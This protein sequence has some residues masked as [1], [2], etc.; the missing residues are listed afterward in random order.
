MATPENVEFLI[1]V[2]TEVE[3]ARAR[4]GATAQVDGRFEGAIEAGHLVI[5]KAGSVTGTARTETA[6]IHG[7]FRG[8]I[9]VAGLL[10]VRSSGLVE[11]EISYGSLAI[12]SGGQ[13]VGAL[14]QAEPG[15]TEARE[16][17]PSPAPAVVREVEAIAEVEAEPDEDWT[18]EPDAAV[19]TAVPAEPAAEPAPAAEKKKA[20]SRPP[21]A[22]K[23]APLGRAAAAKSS[24]GA[25]ASTA[26]TTSRKT[27]G[28]TAGS[29]KTTDDI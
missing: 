14:T 21:K 16:Q 24:A 15:D 9:E 10:T 27:G 2:E 13:L 29:R 20:P 6:E 5:G 12:D 19:E 25:K 1:G 11:G 23:P 4:V 17:A 7:A 22:S 18:I 28:K 8:T 26:K 3:H